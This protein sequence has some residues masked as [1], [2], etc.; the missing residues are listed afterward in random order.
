MNGFREEKMAQCKASPDWIR[1]SHIQK[2]FI[3]LSDIAIAYVI[4]LIFVVGV[5]F[6]GL[7]VFATLAS[8]SANDILTLGAL[9][10]V[11]VVSSIGFGWV[12]YYLVRRRYKLQWS[13]IG[14]TLDN[15]QRGLLWALALFPIALLV[16]VLE[17]QGWFWLLERYP[18]RFLMSMLAQPEYEAIRAYGV[19]GICVALIVLILILITE[20]IF[21]WGLVYNALE[22]KVS[23]VWHGILA[24]G[25]IFFVLSP[26]QFAS[27]CVITFAF[28]R[29]R[30]LLTPVTMAIGVVLFFQYFVESTWYDAWYDAARF[31]MHGN[32]TCADDGTPLDNGVVTRGG[33]DYKNVTVVK[34]SGGRQEGKATTTSS[35]TYTFQN[36]PPRG[37]HIEI[38]VTS[39]HYHQHGTGASFSLKK[40]TYSHTEYLG[41][42]GEVIE[43]VERNF[44]LKPDTVEPPP[45]D[46]N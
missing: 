16:H 4:A 15:W 21:I 11:G 14:L 18:I 1:T 35:G 45:G 29:T 37:Y 26:L 5:E 28:T 13:E 10:F 9:L 30:T 7:I 27:V 23:S 41:D 39:T 3:R 42:V 2:P 17:A 22:R 6:L 20:C 44:A 40:C 25:L 24:M 38:T 33:N 34:W 36:A 32:C 43:I 8:E 31:T 19:M 46:P 12:I